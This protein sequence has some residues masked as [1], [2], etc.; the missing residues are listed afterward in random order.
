MNKIK[1]LDRTLSRCTYY[2]GI[3]YSKK[4]FKKELKQF[5]INKRIWPDF[6]KSTN[7]ARVNYFTMEGKGIAFVCLDGKASLKRKLTSVY[8]IL[9]HEATHI[10]QAHLEE[11]GGK[12]SSEEE[13]YAIQEISQ[14]LI[15]AYNEYRKERK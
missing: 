15:E 5:K 2:Y 13:A 8:G 1:W 11:I 10:W 3:C 4:Q 9:V 7:F 14:N 6:I 12:G